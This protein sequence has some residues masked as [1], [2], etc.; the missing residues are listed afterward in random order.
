MHQ[1]VESSCFI[2]Q[3]VSSTYHPE[4]THRPSAAFLA[5]LEV[6]E[7]TAYSAVVALRSAHFPDDCRRDLGDM[8]RTSG[9]RG[10]AQADMHR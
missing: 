9:R 2:K 6:A 1:P 8:R 10:A 4:G 5:S 3:T 7:G